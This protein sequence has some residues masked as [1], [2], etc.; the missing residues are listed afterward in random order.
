MMSFDGWNTAYMGLDMG[1]A[2]SDA[3]MHYRTPGSK[4]GVRRY[5]NVDGTW[6]P[7]GLR[8]RRAREGFGEGKEGRR[9]ARK[10]A[11]AERKAI[12]AE[13]RAA[14]GKVVKQ[15]LFK[16]KESIRKRSTKRLTDEEL[17]KRINRLKMEKEYRELNQNPV[18]KT[19]LDL[20]NKYFANKKEQRKYN[21]DMGRIQADKMK[22]K[23]E[24]KTARANKAKAKA[25]K[26]KYKNEERKATIRGAISKFGHDIISKRGNNYVKAVGDE[27]RVINARNK[28][29]NIL[30][31]QREHRE[32]K[33]KHSPGYLATH[34]K[35][36]PK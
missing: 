30:Q 12:R 16:A 26:I 15:Q 9:E 32:S 3:L 17:Q 35:H 25:E 18:V 4:N 27:S 5:Q 2:G 10:A 34:G 33:G 20:V 22:A 11:K 24:M 28:V 21:V 29:K 36:A 23:A 13:K 6:T 1:P 14:F 31:R 19:G 8:E 7:L